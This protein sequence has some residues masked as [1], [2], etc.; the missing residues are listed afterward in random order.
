MKKN[1]ELVKAIDS[2]IEQTLADMRKE[3]VSDTERLIMSASLE[4]LFRIKAGEVSP[5]FDDHVKHCLCEMEVARLKGDVDTYHKLAQSLDS[6]TK[7]QANITPRDGGIGLAIIDG[8]VTLAGTLIIANFDR[9][10]V[11]PKNVLDWFKF[12]FRKR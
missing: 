9:L 8:L 4:N 10:H 3:G 1:R 7:S 5:G 12:S 11:L 2:E 6:I